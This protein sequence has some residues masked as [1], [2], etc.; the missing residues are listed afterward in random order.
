MAQTQQ[1]MWIFGYGSLVWKADFEYSKRVVGFIKSYK[2]RFW[3]AS[4]EH[5]GTADKPGRVVTLI[6]AED[7]EAKVWGVAYHLTDDVAKIQAGL[8]IREQRYDKR[9][10]VPMFE[11][12]EGQQLP[13]PVL[14][15]VGSS[16]PDLFLGP[17]SLHQMALQITQSKGPSGTNVEYLLRLAQFMREEA[18]IAQD[19]H[20]FEVEGAVRQL[21]NTSS[22]D[23]KGSE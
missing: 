23:Q 16:R 14:V 9:K 3:Q 21:L 15:F 5:R 1:S 18:P 19:P 7:P 11:G 2:R 8:D 20:L 17:A 6:P 10:L 13:H 4:I 22:Q 12:E